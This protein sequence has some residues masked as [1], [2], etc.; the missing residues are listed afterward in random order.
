MTG[1][2]HYRNSL[3]IRLETWNIGTLNGKGLKICDE[4]WK[5]NVDL[6]LA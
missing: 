1:D 3:K 5:M 6:D 2:M 4:L